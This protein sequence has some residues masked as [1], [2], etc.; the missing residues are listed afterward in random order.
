MTKIRKK[1][2]SNGITIYNLVKKAFPNKKGTE[3]KTILRK[4]YNWIN[5]KRMET[6]GIKDILEKAGYPELYDEEDY[7]KKNYYI[8]K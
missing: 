8:A 2:Q 6:N 1:L 3:F 5:G 4:T 7:I